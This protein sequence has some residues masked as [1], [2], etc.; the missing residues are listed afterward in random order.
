MIIETL[1]S[2]ARTTFDLKEPTHQESLYT[3]TEALLEMSHLTS[4]TMFSGVTV[5]RLHLPM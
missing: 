3:L 4:E 5:P 1:L 2:N